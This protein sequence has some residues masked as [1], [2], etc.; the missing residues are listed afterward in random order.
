MAQ[1]FT[2]QMNHIAKKFQAAMLEFDSIKLENKEIKQLLN[3][4][5][6]KYDEDISSLKS[7]N[8]INELKFSENRDIILNQNTELHNQKQEIKNLDI[9]HSRLSGKHNDLVESF[10]KLKNDHSNLQSDQSMLA[11]KPALYQ[12]EKSLNDYKEN[13]DFVM[14][15]AHS[16]IKNILDSL[17]SNSKKL[18]DN[19]SD[20]SFLKSVTNTNTLSI[21]NTNRALQLHKME[22]A[23]SI[24]NSIA[25]QERKIN[26]KIAAIP[27]PVIPSIDQ[28][29][30]DVKDQVNSFS[31]DIKKSNDRSRDNEAKISLHD[32]QIKGLQE[33]ITKLQGVKIVSVGFE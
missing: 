7:K 4:L 18:Q 32:K 25:D 12:V 9:N 11:T 5:F 2:E 17:D 10:N 28:P 21:A 13:N 8:Q 22:T 20:I 24:N 14:E 1:D 26:S 33:Q 30:Q 15:E 3:K 16:L 31:T 27:L 23:E 29:I 6:I 19:Q